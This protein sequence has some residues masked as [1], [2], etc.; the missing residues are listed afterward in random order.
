MTQPLF[1]LGGSQLCHF[2]NYWFHTCDNVVLRA[3][4]LVWF[5]SL[6]C[7]VASFSLHAVYIL[8]K[9][10]V[11]LVQSLPLWNA[12]AFWPRIYWGILTNPNR[13]SLRD[14]LMDPRFRRSSL[15]GPWP[16]SRL[17]RRKFLAKNI[18]RIQPTI[19]ARLPL[20]RSKRLWPLPRGGSTSMILSGYQNLIGSFAG[21]QVVHLTTPS[22]ASLPLLALS[23]SLRLC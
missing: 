5:V 4:I 3:D 12:L 8:L 15:N 18:V 1:L 22:R 10:I 6:A 7:Q 23:C 13:R 2:Y 9:L 21:G 17:T 19:L 16:V 11:A 20:L 14:M